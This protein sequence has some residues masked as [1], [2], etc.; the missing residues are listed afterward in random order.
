[1]AGDFSPRAV[2]KIGSAPGL[3]HGTIPLLFSEV[4][5]GIGAAS[6]SLDTAAADLIA[7]VGP[8]PQRRRGFERRDGSPSPALRRA[9]T[10]RSA[11]RNPNTDIDGMCA[12][13]DPKIGLRL[14]LTGGKAWRAASAGVA[15]ADYIRQKSLTG[16]IKATTS[17]CR[18]V[19]SMTSLRIESRN[20]GARASAILPT[21]VQILRSGIV[22]T[23]PM[24]FLRPRSKWHRLLNSRTDDAEK[25]YL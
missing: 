20:S 22:T 23:R 19:F 13:T 15:L 17:T 18:M 3:P 14:G 7:A 5:S 8:R 11:V 16:R 4:A 24:N 21:A 9:G 2:K 6:I 10:P 1:M 12:R 25:D